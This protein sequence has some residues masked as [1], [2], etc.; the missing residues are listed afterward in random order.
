MKKDKFVED[1][2]LAYDM[3]RKNRRAVLYGAVGLLALIIGVWAFFAWRGTQERKAHSLLA[4]AI[5]VM[6]ADV[7]TPDPAAPAAR[8]Q[9]A[10]ED[11]KFARAEPMF[12]DVE[13]RYS[14]TDAADVAGLYLA[15]IAAAR[16]DAAS[17]RTRLEKFVRSHS[18][19]ILAGTAQM[20]LYELR[21]QGGAGATEVIAEVEKE[22]AR[23]GG[24][25][26]KD[27]LLAF[28]ARAY[29]SSGAHDK[30]R[31]VY[32]RVI[33]EYPDSPYAIDAQRKLAAA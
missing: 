2:G 26:P 25:L 29:E 17:A 10:T 20:S 4:E 32:Q 28:L 31:D 19:H 22:L 11:E 16:G 7:G 8:P 24:P 21:L 18:D 5:G 27:A 12:A 15:R 6:E 13:Q 33:S 23:E 14:G 9:F 1:V 3:A 30:A